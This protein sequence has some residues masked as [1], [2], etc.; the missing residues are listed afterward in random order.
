LLCLFDVAVAV[1]VV[2]LPGVLA[3]ERRRCDVLRKRGRERRR[4]DG[5]DATRTRRRLP[6]GA[7]RHRSVL[8]SRRLRPP[9][10]TR[11]GTRI[12]D[13]PG[14]ELTL[15]RIQP[16]RALRSGPNFSRFAQ[17]SV[18]AEVRDPADDRR[19]FRGSAFFDR[20]ENR[21]IGPV[22][23]LAAGI[24]S[25]VGGAAFGRQLLRRRRSSRRQEWV[26]RC[27]LGP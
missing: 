12:G 7:G 1:V 27:K 3:Q 16:V 6:V 22:N 8:V 24:A 25:G 5:A 9:A 23:G 4:R 15:V 19:R 13:A 26:S 11:T 21:K 2:V 10:S 20:F 18:R 17:A 14:S